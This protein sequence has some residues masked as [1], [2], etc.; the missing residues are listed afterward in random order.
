MASLS[1]MLASEPWTLGFPYS[2]K[3]ITTSYWLLQPLLL[4]QWQSYISLESHLW[5][6]LLHPHLPQG[7]SHTLRTN[8]L[9]IWPWLGKHLLAVSYLCC[10]CKQT[11]SDLQNSH[12]ISIRHQRQRRT[13]PILGALSLI[14]IIPIFPSWFV[15]IFQSHI[16]CYKTNY[17][18]NTNHLGTKTNP[19]AHSP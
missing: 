15:S 10:C 4:L 18:P 8:C 3:L 16:C 19:Q 9:C 14:L 1:L 17:R 2:S 6:L 5:E 12:H 13:S 11:I 7:V